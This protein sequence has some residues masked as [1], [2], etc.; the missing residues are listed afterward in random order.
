MEDK[1]KHECCCGDHSSTVC[2]MVAS[3][4]MNEQAEKETCCEVSYEVINDSGVTNAT[5]TVDILTLLLNCPQAPPDI[6]TALS[7]PTPRLMLSRLSPMT[8]EA[9]SF[10]RDQ[11]TYLFTRRLRI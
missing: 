4:A 9:Q 11:E 1:P 2:P 6:G 3:C 5:S 10:F 8:N 7:T